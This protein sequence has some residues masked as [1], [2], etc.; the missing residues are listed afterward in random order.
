VRNGVVHLPRG[1]GLG[2]QVDESHVRRMAVASFRIRA[3]N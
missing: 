3:Q 2:L 1:A